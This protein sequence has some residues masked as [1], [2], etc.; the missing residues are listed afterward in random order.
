M[1]VSLPLLIGT[2]VLLDQAST[3]MTSF[4]LNFL[5]KILPPNTVTSKLTLQLMNLGGHNSVHYR[6]D[7]VEGLDA[8]CFFG[9]V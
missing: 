5:L 7:D 1:C 6:G 9:T 4:N 2:S 3:L 8:E